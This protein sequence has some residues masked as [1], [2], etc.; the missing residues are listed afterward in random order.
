MF[1]NEDLLRLLFWWQ[2]I[3]VIMFTTKTIGLLGA[4]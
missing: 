4:T 1:I 3:A 2:V